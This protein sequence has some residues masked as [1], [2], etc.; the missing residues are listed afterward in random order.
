MALDSLTIAALT[1][2]LNGELAGAKI[3]KISMPRPFEV[4]LGLHSAGG[5]R[6]LLLSAGGT[7]AGVYLTDSK[8]E[9]PPAPPMLC[10]LLRKHLLAGRILEI[11]QPEGERMTELV[12]SSQDELGVFSEKRLICELIGRRTNIILADKEGII[13]GCLKRVDFESD[14]TRSVMPGMLYRMPKKQEKP[15]LFGMEEREILAFIAAAPSDTPLNELFDGVAPVIAKELAFSCPS[16]EE[17]ASA[18]YRLAKGEGRPYM[19]IKHGAPTDFFCLPM[20]HI[21]EG[22]SR[23]MDS[24]SAM[25]DSFYGGQRAEEVRKSLSSGLEKTVKSSIAKLEKKLGRQREERQSAKGREKLKNHADLITANIYAIKSGDTQ[26]TVTDYFDEAMPSV[27][28]KLDPDLSPQQNAQLLYKRYTRMKNAEEA[29]EKQLGQGER[30]LEYLKT[31]MFSIGQAMGEKDMAA[32]RQELVEGGYIRQRA[33]NGKPAKS[34]APAFKR[35]YTD[36]GFLVLRGRNNRENEQLSLHTAKGGD[37]WFHTK[38]APGSHVVLCLEG[39]EASDRAMEQAAALAAFHSGLWQQPKVPV[40]YTQVKWVKKLQGGQV[41][42]V[43]YFNYKTLLVQ[44]CD[45]QED[46]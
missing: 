45:M 5:N 21:E 37:L 46:K 29:L 16:A 19:I 28:I 12:I 15:Q 32:I 38:N 30:E 9:N 24:F 14:G 10:M 6:R 17:Q 33:V 2:E 4:V 8:G 1:K 20:T 13:L 25:I 22:E 3:D 35:Y 43:N 18:L 39:R 34:A 36:D 40:D 27:T 41:G 31:V 23:L 11:R 44:P 7:N 42:M 26:A